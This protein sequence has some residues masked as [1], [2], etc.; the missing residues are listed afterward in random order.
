MRKTFAVMMTAMLSLGVMT[1][2]GASGQSAASTS[3]SAAAAVSSSTAASTESAQA[4]TEDAQGASTEASAASNK[5]VAIVV[6]YSVDPEESGTLS[7]V[8]EYLTSMNG[9]PA[10]A[11]G[12][13]ATPADGYKFVNWT[14]K[15]GN[16]V[17]KDASFVPQDVTGN[18]D[19]T[20]HFEKAN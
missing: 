10:A 5:P 15:D 6:T 18:L 2:C 9:Q 7:R 19:F 12:S 17:S 11:K 4:S 1:G 8:K 13:E 14:D 3:T 20:A 16:E